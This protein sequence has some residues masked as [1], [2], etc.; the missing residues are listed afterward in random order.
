[1]PHA[2]PKRS[3]PRR[4]SQ[5][6]STELGTL[7]IVTGFP[8]DLTGEIEELLDHLDNY[9]GD[10]VKFIGASLIGVL[11]PD[12]VVDAHFTELSPTAL[13]LRV[14]LADSE[15]AVRA[16][17]D[18][19][20][21]HSGLLHV[22]ITQL[23]RAARQRF[24]DAPPTAIE[25]EMLETA[26]LTTV[27]ATVVRRTMLTPDLAQ[28]T[29]SG[30]DHPV[31]G[32]DEYHYIMVPENPDVDLTTLSPEHASTAA[33]YTA[34][35]RRAVDHEMDLWVVLH[36]TDLGVSG[37]ASRTQP[38]DQVGVWGP[39]QTFHPPEA[40]TKLLLV[41]DASGY[42]AVASILDGLPATQEALV[43]A[44]VTD[45]AH[46][47]PLPDGPRIEIRWVERQ[48]E[49]PGGAGVLP[50]AVEALTL[51]A[52]GLYVFGAGESREMTRV[53]R[54]VRESL[55]LGRDQVSALAYW[56]AGQ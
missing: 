19:S 16:E 55:G 51:D 15:H 54:Y 47:P 8:T 12:L 52:D 34:R 37:W 4:C 24:P 32:G 39:Q 13:S 26:N 20:I 43:L 38:G 49:P 30:V 48:G 25:V 44:E 23:L 1:M 28:I 10:A 5:Q 7:I 2:S 27:V 11:T 41:C 9:H 33:Y 29:L 21:E 18:E 3:S 40:T 17:F 35:A 6:I 56:R 36:A 14:E 53:R 42:A 46:H 31:L 22:E 45:A 50:A